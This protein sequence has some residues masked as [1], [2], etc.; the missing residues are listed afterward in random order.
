M[1]KI[2][3]ILTLFLAISSLAYAKQSLDYTG[4]QRVPV[5]LYHHILRKEENKK[6]KYNSGVITPELFAQQIKLLHDNGYKTIT[7]HELEQFITKKTTLPKKSVVITFDDGYLSNLTYAYPI[8][9]KY[10]YTA[11]LFLITE[12]IR[13]Q[14][15]TF[16]P[17]KLNYISWPELAKYSDVFQY[18]GHT[19]GFHRTVGSTSFL[20][21]KSPEDVLIDLELSKMLLH[22]HYFAYPYGQYNKNTIQLVK[23]AGYTMAFTT[24][25]TKAKPGTSPFEVPRYGILSTTTM[26]QFKNIIGIP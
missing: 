19:D 8:L 4:A 9:K 11:A 17:D 1:Q 15:E 12:N 5:L 16:N 3:I 24:R 18:E 23:K 14:P 21:A 10:N 2:I 25:P 20:L 13:S 6:F 26:Q 7:L 22:T